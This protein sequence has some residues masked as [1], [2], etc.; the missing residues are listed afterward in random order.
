M[1]L[2]NIPVSVAD[3]DRKEHTRSFALD[4]IRAVAILMVV[5]DHGG[6]LPP[7]WRN[8]LLVAVG[9]GAM[10]FMAL[11]GAL[12]L[13]VEGSY[14]KFLLRRVRRVLVP[15]LFWFV[16]LV[17]VR[18]AQGALEPEYGLYMLRW[19]WLTPFYGY[20]WFIFIITALYLFMP[21]ISPWIATASRR[22]I[23][24]YLL[25]WAAAGLLPWL[26]GIMGID[27]ESNY[28]V[29]FA[30]F[31]GYCVLGFYL[32]RFPESLRRRPVVVALTVVL[33]V[34]VPVLCTLRPAGTV[35]WLHVSLDR[36]SV[37]QFA[38]CALIFA[39]LLKVRTLGRFLNP[40]VR[41]LSRDSYGIYLVHIIIG[42]AVV[43]RYFPEIEQT[44]WMIPVYIIGSLIVC[45]AVRRIPFVGKYLV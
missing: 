6:F 18:M 33:A 27:L 29:M 38:Q 19:G 21:V 40:V 45:E 7:M 11:S 25:L 41:L 14:R 16:V 39:L 1:N 32:V 13:P 23:E 20:L 30:N 36:L 15:Y 3:A 28:F 34:I 4:L 26:H 24:Y 9:S 31:F 8:L 5:A 22:H 17:G 43:G 10:L 2:T 42:R 37:T 35:D 44:L 12:L